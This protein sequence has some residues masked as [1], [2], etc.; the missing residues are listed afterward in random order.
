M[1]RS[2]DSQQKK[3]NLPNHNDFAILTDH[4][5]KLKENDKKNF[6]REMKILWNMKVTMILIVIGEL[7]TVT[8]KVFKKWK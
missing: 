8:K 2:S 7:D 6:V 1:T 3:E 5:V 4:K